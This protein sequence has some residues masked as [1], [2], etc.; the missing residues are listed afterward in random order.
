MIIE[1]AKHRINEAFGKA[2]LSNTEQELIYIYN[3]LLNYDTI[4]SVFDY[5]FRKGYDFKTRH[6]EYRFVVIVYPKKN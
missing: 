1:N 6:D 5:I 2:D 4:T 3:E